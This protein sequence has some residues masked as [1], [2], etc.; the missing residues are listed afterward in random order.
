VFVPQK[1]RLYIYKGK[2][3]PLQAWTDPGGFRSSRLPDFKTIGIWKWDVC[4]TYTPATLPCRKHSWYSSLL[5]AGSIMSGNQ[6]RDLS[7]CSAVPQ[8][9]ALPRAPRQTEIFHWAPALLESWKN[10]TTRNSTKTNTKYKNLYQYVI[11]NTG[12]IKVDDYLFKYGFQ[13][14]VQAITWI[15]KKNATL[16]VMR[17]GMQRCNTFAQC[18]RS[19][20]IHNKRFCN[21]LKYDFINAT[22]VSD[23][24]IDIFL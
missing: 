21:T 22:A 6:T 5:E 16:W 10:S 24:P 3:I 8:P 9:T 13:G 11:Q 15:K 23:F 4:Q 7:T 1:Y 19:M 17:F 2:A 18:Q 20:Q 14:D 12:Q